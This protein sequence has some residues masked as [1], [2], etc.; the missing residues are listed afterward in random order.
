MR[1]R[2]PYAIAALVT[3]A[4]GLGLRSTMDGGVAKYGGDALYTLLV[5]WLVLVVAPRLN[6]PLAG[7]IACAFSWA[8]E[9]FQLSPIPGELSGN[10]LAR[11]VLGST[12]NAPDLFWYVVGAAAGV[13][14][15]RVLRTTGRA[16]QDRTTVAADT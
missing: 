5:F 10:P 1:I 15:W 3:V 16:A 2:A 8:I 14:V 12:F 9:F 13:A 4:L 7:A 11:L 6:G